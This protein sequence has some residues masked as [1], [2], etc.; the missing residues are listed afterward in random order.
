MIK[1]VAKML[2]SVWHLLRVTDQWEDKDWYKWYVALFFFALDYVFLKV[3]GLKT[4]A[5][6]ISDVSRFSFPFISSSNHI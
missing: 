2:Q 4:L 5:G 6:F 1:P 3:L